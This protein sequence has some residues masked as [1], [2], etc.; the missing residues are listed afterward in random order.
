MPST[1]TPLANVQ[2]SDEPITN[3]PLYP[4]SF[5]NV[6]DRAIGAIAKTNNAMEASHS[7]FLVCNSISFNFFF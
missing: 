6:H 2:R 5:W 1:S 7:H 3:Q 4:I